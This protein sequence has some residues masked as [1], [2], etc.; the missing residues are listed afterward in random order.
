MGQRLSDFT[1]SPFTSGLPLWAL[2]AGAFSLKAVSYLAVC[3]G[4]LRLSS[5]TKNEMVTLLAG[6]GAA[7]AVTVI[8]RYLNL[9]ANLLLIQLLR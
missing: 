4:G 5:A 2:L 8:L 7:G 3:L 6:V 9:D 1:Q